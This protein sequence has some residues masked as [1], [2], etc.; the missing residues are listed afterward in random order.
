M[1]LY[2]P[3]SVW[4]LV[5]CSFIAVILA[6]NSKR[7]GTAR[8]RHIRTPTI[9]KEEKGT[10]FECVSGPYILDFHGVAPKV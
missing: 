9:K 2:R 8:V 5:A 3:H 6:K 4:Q 7:S 10:L 1:K